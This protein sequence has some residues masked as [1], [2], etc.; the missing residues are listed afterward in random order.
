MILSI[1]PAS[2]AATA[3][4]NATAVSGTKLKMAEE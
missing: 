2:R 1:V 3:S 4:W